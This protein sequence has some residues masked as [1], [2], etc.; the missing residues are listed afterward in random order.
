MKWR[1]N[2]G[3]SRLR[4][5]GRSQWGRA[6]RRVAGD[7]ATLLDRWWKNFRYRHG[8]RCSPSS[9]HRSA[10]YAEPLGGDCAGLPSSRSRAVITVPSS[11]GRL[12]SRRAPILDVRRGEV[13]GFVSPSGAGLRAARR[14]RPVSR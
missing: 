7:G 11:A 1:R 10:E 14:R 2:P 12:D 5:E 8:R 6:R 9:S 3:S 4:L 13:P